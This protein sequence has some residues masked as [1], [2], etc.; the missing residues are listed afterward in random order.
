MISLDPNLLRASISHFFLSTG[1][2]CTEILRFFSGFQVPLCL[3]GEPVR[4]EWRTSL[5]SRS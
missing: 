1:I 4:G 2:R 3:R 5:A